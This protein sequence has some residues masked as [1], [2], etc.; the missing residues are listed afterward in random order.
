MVASVD[1]KLRTNLRDDAAFVVVAAMMAVIFM[2]STLVTPLYALYRH[3]FGFSEFM[4]TLV[5]A[6]YVVGNFVAL[7]IFGRLSDEIGRKPVGIA[8]LGLAGLSTLIFLAAF[9][10]GW[11]FW[12]RMLSG[13]GVGLAS[14]T[15]AAWLAE[16]DTAEQKSR[17]T[18]MTSTANFIGIALGPLLSGVLAQYAPWPLHLSF[19]VYLAILAIVG[20]LLTRTP[21]T[22]KTPHGSWRT[23]SLRPRLGIPAELRFSFIAPA[24]TAFATFAVIGFYAALLP[25]ILAESLHQ[26]NIA[27]GGAVVF[28]L[29]LI[30]ALMTI[31]TRHFESRIAM[32]SGLVLLLPSV[33]LLVMAQTLGSILI[34]LAGTALSGCAA[35]LGYRGSL[36]VVNKIAPDE[37]RAEIVSS[38]YVAMFLGNS[39]PVIG[40]GLLT[41]V[42][43]SSLASFVFA[44]VIAILAICALVTGIKFNPKSRA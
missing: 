5:Y 15:A 37:Q 1:Q 18:L 13:F 21:E 39:V 29:F 38:F 12:A 10:T 23:L 43:S 36:Q 41:V 17:A 33:A 7:L 26:T 34:L 24:V 11:L 9:S 28:E 25:T 20:V 3:A 2:G 19:L 35:A 4:L 44:C 8:S 22:V 31:A 16:L 42:A 27:V 32:L 6:V 14:G 30:A 40:V